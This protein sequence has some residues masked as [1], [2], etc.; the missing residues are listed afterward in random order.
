MEHEQRKGGGRSPTK[1]RE[2]N[3]PQRLS[4]RENRGQRLPTHEQDCTTEAA[5]KEQLRYDKLNAK[6]QAARLEQQSTTRQGQRQSDA[7]RKAARQ[8]QRQAAAAGVDAVANP[9]RA[10]CPLAHGQTADQRALDEAMLAQSQHNEHSAQI[11]FWERTGLDLFPLLDKVE[12]GTATEQD[13]QALE[14][15][16]KSLALTQEDQMRIC[17]QWATAKTAKNL[18]V[19]RTLYAC[20]VCGIRDLSASYTLHN[21]RTEPDELFDAQVAAIDPMSM[22]ETPKRPKRAHPAD[23]TCAALELSPRERQA[24]MAHPGKKLFSVFECHDDMDTPRYYWLKPELVVAANT[25]DG[26]HDDDRS[27]FFDVHRC[28]VNVCSDCLGDLKLDKRPKYGAG[29]VDDAPITDRIEFGDWGR[30]VA[31]FG[32]K[33][34]SLCEKLLVRCAPICHGARGMS[35]LSSMLL[36]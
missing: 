24:Y 19:N 3:G 35:R 7:Q 9:N 29:P 8:E 4:T 18:S 31:A 14:Q 5:R 2:T 10:D 33:P 22:D 36:L 28:S 1:P 21:L 30:F 13:I 27:E 15:Q 17:Q 34:L 20:G 23:A 12:E 25:I 11:A 6:K 26:A 16:I 32:C